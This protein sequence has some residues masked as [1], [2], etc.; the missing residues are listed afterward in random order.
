MRWTEMLPP[1]VV[2][3]EVRSSTKQTREQVVKLEKLLMEHEDVF[4]RDAQDLGCTLLLCG[5]DAQHAVG[6]RGW[7]YNPCKKRGITLKLQSYWKHG[8]TRIPFWNNFR[9]SLTSWVMAQVGGRALSTSTGCGLLWRMDTSR[10]CQTVSLGRLGRVTYACEHESCNIDRQG[11]ESGRRWVQ[12]Q[13]RNIKDWRRRSSGQK[14][15]STNKLGIGDIRNT[16]V[17]KRTPA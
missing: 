8:K 6:D 1:H 5:G 13:H 10:A 2:D 14:P 4:S 16:P 15:A 7:R 11:T 9:P 12:N 17:A 3:L